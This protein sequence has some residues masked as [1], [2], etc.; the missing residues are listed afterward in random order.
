VVKDEDSV[1]SQKDLPLGIKKQAP[2]VRD[3][4]VQVDQPKHA[5]V[6][7]PP[8]QSSGTSSVRTMAMQT[9]LL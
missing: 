6:N 4:A 9:D 8:G 2:S 5:P 7:V 3:I 1:L